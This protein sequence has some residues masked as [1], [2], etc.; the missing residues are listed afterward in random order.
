MLDEGRPDF[1]VAF[2]G[3]RGTADMCRRAREAGLEVVEITGPAP[4]IGSPPL[5]SKRIEDMTDAEVVEILGPP[6]EITAACV[7][8]VPR[9]TSGRSQ[10]H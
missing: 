6:D 10:E 5:M 1:V 9:S 2:P 7:N 3:G 4:R 8:H